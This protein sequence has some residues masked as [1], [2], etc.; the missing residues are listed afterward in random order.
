MLSNI[1]NSSYRDSYGNQLVYSDDISIAVYYDTS[2]ESWDRADTTA[3][4]YKERTLPNDSFLF[5]LNSDIWSAFNYKGTTSSS[6]STDGLT[7]SISKSESRGGLT[8]EGKWQLSGDFSV[9]IFVNITCYLDFLHSPWNKVTEMNIII[10][11]FVCNEKTPL[12]KFHYCSQEYPVAIVILYYIPL[13]D[14][15]KFTFTAFNFGVMD[16]NIS[17]TIVA[18]NKPIAFSAIEPFYCSFNHC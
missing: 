7:L 4:W 14:Y 10:P 12:T 13:V 11:R 6:F 16:K 8:S 1:I 5:G 18:C 9:A 2:A 3:S 17:R 15:F